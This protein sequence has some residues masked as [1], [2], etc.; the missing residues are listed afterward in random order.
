MSPQKKQTLKPIRPGAVA[1]WMLNDASTPAEKSAFLKSCREGGF[2]GMVLHPRSGNRIPYASDE[3][4]AMI[5]HLIEEGRRLDMD[6]WLYD[7]DPYPSGAAGGL[8]MSQRPDLKAYGM[9]WV[10]CP[11]RELKPGNLWRI[12]EQQVL[13][14]GWV[15]KD[16]KRDV[17]NLT[18]HVGPLRQEWFVTPWDSRYYYEETPLVDC[19][20]GDAVKLEYCLRIPERKP[21]YQLA[22]VVLK[23]AGVEGPWGSLPD[24]LN[25]DAFACF[26]Q[27]TLDRYQQEVGQH[28]GK[29]IPG[30]F[31]D[32]AKPNTHWPV[33]SGLWSS[34]KT[35]FGYDLRSCLYRLFRSPSGPG[36]DAVRLDYRRWVLDR[37]LSSFVKPYRRYCDSVGLRLVGHFSPEDDPISEVP[38]IASVMPI[39]R[40]AGTPGTDLIIPLVGNASAPTLNLGSLRAASIRSRDQTSYCISESL[41]LSRWSVTSRKGRHIL[42]WQKVLG[43]DRF[44]IHGFANSVEGVVNHEAPPS[45]GP[46]NSIFPGMCVLNAWLKRLEPSMDHADEVAPVAI[47]NS[48]YSFWTAGATADPRHLQSRSSLWKTLLHVLSAQ[49]GVHLID[50]SELETG[51]KILRDGFRVGARTYSTLLVPDYDILG[52]P[53]IDAMSQMVNAGLRVVH[54]GG[55]A[56]RMLPLK[57]TLQTC[58]TLPGEIRSE[59]W[60]TLAWCRKELPQHVCITGVSVGEVMS[61]RFT[62][63]QGRDRLLV[64]NM[65]DDDQVFRVASVEEDGRW[66]PVEVDGDIAPEKTSLMWSVPAGG[67]GLFDYQSDALSV[68]RPLLPSCS[69]VR[70]LNL[71]DK[72]FQRLGANVVRL[73]DVTVVFPDGSPQKTI[74]YPQPFWRCCD[75]YQNYRMLETYAGFVPLESK[76]GLTSMTYRFAFSVAKDFSKPLKLIMDPRCARGVCSVS[77]NGVCLRQ[78]Q[79]FPLDGITPLRLPLG[80]SLRHGKNLLEISFSLE[81]AL[82]GL[83]G[84]LYLEGDFDLQIR[85]TG[86]RLEKTRHRWSSTGW[87]DAGMPHYMGRGVYRWNESWTSEDLARAGT[88]VLEL[89]KV[90]DNAECFM[91]GQSLGLLAWKPWRWTLPEVTPG[92]HRFELVVSGTAGNRHELEWP[93][94]PQGWIGGGRW[95]FLA[96]P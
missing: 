3:W 40:A 30:I 84:Q 24:L 34:F 39:M 42:A 78:H 10:V 77:L 57:G 29:T 89:D 7:E 60:P 91:D 23:P 36:D 54:F 64:V 16:P 83:L 53:A 21:G 15:P 69:I 43:I 13:W 46:N 5:S 87:Q 86:L 55:G 81:T 75:D 8:V 4:F 12:A 88:W 25:P 37:F 31:T 11:Q 18:G 14:A 96:S 66:L 90:T 2:E 79:A 80:T 74:S 52:Q 73:S 85:P 6:M 48:L 41:A 51:V 59:K 65:T 20:R 47:L 33:T 58:Q 93:N 17:V 70:D 35:R 45:F 22:A 61:R 68:E 26:K 32:E 9:H 71:R 50:E 62:D 94:Q 56:K 76:P 92:H 44:F 19:V 63:V 72:T 27:I 28:F 49:V 38:N 67:C 82:D 95:L 1:F